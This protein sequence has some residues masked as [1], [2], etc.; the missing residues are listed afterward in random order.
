MPKILVNLICQRC[1]WIVLARGA[2]RS[3]LQKVLVDRICKRWLSIV[4]AEGAC[5]SILRRCFWILRAKDTGQSYLQKVLVDRI[6]ERCWSIVFAQGVGQSC[7]HAGKQ[8]TSSELAFITSHRAVRR[9][10]SP[11]SG[12]T[13]P[14]YTFVGCLFAW[15]I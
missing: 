2:G 13:L 4:F 7:V 3:Y 9:S 5:Q 10:R 1:S 8:I 12:C 6:G 14:T 15:L 11:A